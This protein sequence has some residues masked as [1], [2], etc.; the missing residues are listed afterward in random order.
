MFALAAQAAPVSILNHSFQLPD[1]GGD[2]NIVDEDAYDVANGNPAP[3]NWSF[4]NTAND[5]YGQQRPHPVNHFTRDT[6]DGE[7]APF[8]LG[9]FDGDL[10]VFANM[11]GVGDSHTA[12]SDVLGQLA[13]GTYTLTVAVGGRNTGSWNDINYSVGL[14]GAS[15]GDLGAT[16]VTLDPGA[17]ANNT[18][19]SPWTSDDYNVVDVSFELNVP[20]GSGLIGEDYGVRIFAENSG[21]QGGEANTGFTQAAYDNARLDFVAVPEP[22][23]LALA[24]IGAM[25]ILTVANRRRRS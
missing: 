25:A 19:S 24:G 21:L 18:A 4:V 10:I 17:S 11:N 15:S 23:T 2:G 6:T 13:A 7:F 5:N 20:L 3:S 8:T 1:P 22:S 12:T 14:Y 16:S 9:G